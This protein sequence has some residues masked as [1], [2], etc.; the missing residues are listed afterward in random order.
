MS[1][2]YNRCVFCGEHADTREHIFARCFFDRPF[3]KD[4][5][6]IPSCHNC[7]NSFSGDEQYLMYLIDYLKS[8]EIKNGE[9][10]RDISE[11]TFQHNDGLENRMINSLSVDTK[12]KP[13]LIRIG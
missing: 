4:L 2:L 12:E 1:T 10:T 13:L 7:N 9:F 6:T 3:P 5:L 11:K 8:I